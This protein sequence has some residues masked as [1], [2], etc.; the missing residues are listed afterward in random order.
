MH[1]IYEVYEVFIQLILIGKPSCIIWL[2]YAAYLKYVEGGRS[3]TLMFMQ[4][5]LWS[6]LSVF[7]ISHAFVAKDILSCMY[8]LFIL[9]RESVFHQVVLQREELCRTFYLLHIRSDWEREGSRRKG[10]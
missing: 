8:L 9:S 3:C 2:E 4:K 5:K 1:I 6:E 10:S 7:V